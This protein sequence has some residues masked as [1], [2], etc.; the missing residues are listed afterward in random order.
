MKILFQKWGHFPQG[1]APEADLT[2]LLTPDAPAKLTQARS[3]CKKL[4]FTLSLP[5]GPILIIAGFYKVKLTIL[6]VIR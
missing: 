3:R 2:N 4:K 6:T 5:S 1:I